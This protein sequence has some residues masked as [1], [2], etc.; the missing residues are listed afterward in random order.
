VKK[1][2]VTGGRREFFRWACG[3]VALC[4]CLLFGG[5]ASH[6]TLE[7]DVENPAVRVST[8]GVLFGD[9]RRIG[10]FVLSEATDR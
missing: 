9:D 10:F 4:T 6:R 1:E 2:E 8:L 7:L 3:G 5:C